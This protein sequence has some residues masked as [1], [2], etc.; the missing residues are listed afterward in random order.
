MDSICPVFATLDQSWMFQLKDLL[1]LQAFR[2]KMLV[3]KCAEQTFLSSRKKL[4]QVFCPA[5]PVA[6]S[7]KIYD[8]K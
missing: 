1:K 3:K 5:K 4:R 7:V 6:V 8:V 2:L